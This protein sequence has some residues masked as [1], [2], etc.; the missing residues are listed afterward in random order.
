MKYNKNNVLSEMEGNTSPSGLG[1][2]SPSKISSRKSAQFSEVSF[3]LGDLSIR[4][5]EIRESLPIK[6]LQIAKNLTIGFFL[7]GFGEAREQTRSQT[8]AGSALCSNCHGSVISRG[9][10]LLLY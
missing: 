1:M 8:F 5:A 10:D 4:V 2:A 6:T 3:D 9:H 7:P